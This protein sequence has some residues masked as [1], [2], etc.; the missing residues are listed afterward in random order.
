VFLADVFWLNGVYDHTVLRN[1]TLLFCC[2]ATDR[3]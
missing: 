1:H 2:G 3:R